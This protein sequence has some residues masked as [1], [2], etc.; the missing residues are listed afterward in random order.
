ME[1]SLNKLSSSVFLFYINSAVAV[2]L[3]ELL[4]V[5]ENKFDVFM[6]IWAST[7]WFKGALTPALFGSVQSNPSLFAP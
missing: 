4:E 5:W 1:A 7:G 2:A 6:I 3:A